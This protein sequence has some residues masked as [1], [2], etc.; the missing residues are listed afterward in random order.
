MDDAGSENMAGEAGEAGIGNIDKWFMFVTKSGDG[1]IC[2]DTCGLNCCSGDVTIGGGVGRVLTLLLL[3]LFVAMAVV[4][5]TAAAA[6]VVLALLLLL[7]NW[8]A[9][10]EVGGMAIDDDRARPELGFLNVPGDTG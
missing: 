5:V 2:P 6:A 8:M 7:G 10:G 9:K 1:D 3:I 4:L